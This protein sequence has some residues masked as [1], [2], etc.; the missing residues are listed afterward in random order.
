MRLETFIQYL[1]AVGVTCSIKTKKFNDNSLNYKYIDCIKD[2]LYFEV[3][4]N[5][6]FFVFSMDWYT[7]DLRH[8]I[9]KMLSIEHFFLQKDFFDYWLSHFLYQR[10]LLTSWS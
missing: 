2:G 8:S 10:T 6:D 7:N 5:D 4:K 9:R 1:G 3:R